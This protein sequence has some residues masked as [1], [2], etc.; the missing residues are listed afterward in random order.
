MSP[1]PSPRQYGTV[2][3][4]LNLYLSQSHTKRPHTKKALIAMMGM[5]KHSNLTT[6]C[7]H[8]DTIYHPSGVFLLLAWLVNFSEVLRYIYDFEKGT[9]N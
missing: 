8:N 2:T 4:A 7:P 9:F 1:C 5:P 3:G 6:Q